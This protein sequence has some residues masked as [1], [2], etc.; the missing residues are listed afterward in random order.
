MNLK[1]IGAAVLGIIAVVFGLMKGTDALPTAEDET[2]AQ[3]T[4]QVTEQMNENEVTSQVVEFDLDNTQEAEIENDAKVEIEPTPKPTP[5][6]VV[7]EQKKETVKPKPTKPKSSTDDSN[8]GNQR[9]TYEGKEL[10]LTYHAKCRMGCREISKAEVAEVIEEGK[11]NKRKSNPNDPRCPT[12]ALEDWTEDGQLVRVIIADCDKVAKLV[13]V[14]D[15]K[16]NYKCD[17]K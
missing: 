11:E 3:A 12:I 10:I 7:K 13:T 5:K 17:C 2:T 1:K 15:L 8:P 4:E 6:E 14:I 9:L 16:N